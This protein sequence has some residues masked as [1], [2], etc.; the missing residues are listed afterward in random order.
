V[1]LKLD[2]PAASRKE[3]LPNEFRLAKRT[4][5]HLDLI[6]GLS[7]VAVLL[8]H[9]R[10]LFFVDFPFLVRKS[11]FAKALYAITGYGHQAVIVFFVLSGYFIG[12]SVMESVGKMQWSWR[13]YLVSRLTRLQLVLFPALVLGGIWDRIGMRIPQAIPLY[14][15]ALYKF[16]GASVAVRSTVPVF[17]GNL[18]FLQ[19]ITFPVFGSNGPLW[20]LSYEFW[21]YIAFPLLILMAAGWTGTRTRMLYAGLALFLFWFIGPLLSLYFLIWLAGVL[22]GRIQRAWKY[23]PSP[24]ALSTMGGI[25]FLASLAWCRTHRLYSDLVTDYIVGICFALWLYTLLLGSRDDVS[26]AYARVAKKLAGFSYTL[27]LT[28]FPLLLLLRALINPRGNWQPDLFHIAYAGGIAILV[29]A[30]AYGVAEITEAHT[31]Q[32]R[33]FLLRPAP[34]LQIKSRA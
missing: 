22:A 14:F 20:S 27:Y 24:A 29:L 1:N 30:Y 34:S 15:D 32:V 11:L 10:G 26:P 2:S 18:F 16:N 13:S 7:A 17:F 25:V 8:Y 5:A 33:R 31:A 28:H 4:S 21:Y 6:R 19:S 12:T 9:V 23:K 3:R